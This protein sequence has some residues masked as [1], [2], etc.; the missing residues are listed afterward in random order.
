MTTNR[1][2]LLKAGTST[3]IGSLLATVGRGVAAQEAPQSNAAQI[4]SVP[5][6]AAKIGMRLAT[7]ALGPSGTP[8]LVVVLENFH[9]LI[10]QVG[11]ECF[12]KIF[13]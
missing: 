3:V 9:G 12:H 2:N 10:D 7:C 4:K 8:G 11:R 13:H 1:R 5:P 6:L